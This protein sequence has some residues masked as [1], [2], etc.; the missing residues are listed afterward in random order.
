MKTIIFSFVM[1]FC[2][3]A[4]QNQ[5][6]TNSYNYARVNGDEW[7]TDDARLSA[8]ELAD[9][10][11][12][13]AWLA[14]DFF[15]EKPVP[16]LAMGQVINKTHH[17]LDVDTFVSYLEKSL[18]NSKKLDFIR[19]SELLVRFSEDQLEKRQAS[20][21]EKEYKDRAIQVQATHLLMGKI[22]SS[23]ETEGRR[24]IVFYD[25]N[26]EVADLATGDTEWIGKKRV[27]KI[28]RN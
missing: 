6:T 19:Q 20:L 21:S 17:P 1:I 24:K 7:T 11:V 3:L 22:T 9:N 13:S 10:L 15:V 12:E 8:R 16:K 18:I 4:C 25:I 23:I 28:N 5:P 26:L 14:K 2:L 27:R